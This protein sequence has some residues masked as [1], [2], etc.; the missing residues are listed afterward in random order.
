MLNLC[1]SAALAASDFRTGGANRNGLA[2]ESGQAAS[3]VRGSSRLGA[4]ADSSAFDVV[5]VGGGLVGLASA[6]ALL[7]RSPGLRLA[8]LEK[9]AAP[10]TH[11]SGHNSG[12]V[13]AG[14][15]YEPGSLKARLCRE[16]R[17]RL[18]AF[19][20]EQRIPVHVRGKLVVAVDETELGRLAELRRRGTENGL[21]GLAELADGEWRE[22]E[23]SVR[24]VRALHVPESSVVDFRLVA[25]RLAAQLRDRGA[26]IELGA[27]LDRIERDGDGL[28]LAT[29]RS[30][31]RAGALLACA[32]LQAD[33]VAALAGAAPGIRVVPFRGGYWLLRGRAAGLVRGLVYPVPDPA[34]PFLGVHF[35]RR[36]D[37]EVWAGPNAV[38]A[39]AREGYGR[40]SVSL[41]DA[42]DGLAWPGFLRL[43]R[44]YARTGLLEIWRDTMHGAAVREMQRYLPALSP[45]DVVRGPAGI[46]AQVMRR[47]GQL[48]DDFLVEEGPGSLHVLNAPSPAATSCLAIGQLVAERAA[49]RFGL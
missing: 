32:G 17:E 13:H 28:E 19:C 14:L 9:E 26:R 45:E 7:E 18:A 34:F 46:R 8:V 39:L 25:E 36:F 49:E 41:R 21:A 48:V 11:Q 43:A 33:R 16:G 10:A 3:A 29:S 1:R 22:L 27:R 12:V 23:P 2:C 37:E 6:H 5:V 15:Y 24:G 38:P 20:A 42:A 35:T 40:T 31:L 44:R 30:R 47:D 4:V